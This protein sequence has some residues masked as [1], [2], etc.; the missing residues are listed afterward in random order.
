MKM[1]NNN[2]DID[3][4]RELGSQPIKR[5]DGIEQDVSTLN[6]KQRVSHILSSP[7]FKEELEQAVTDVILRPNNSGDQNFAKEVASY[8]SLNHRPGFKVFEGYSEGGGIQALKA[9]V[10][11]VSPINDLTGSEALSAYSKHERLTR[12]KLAT[13][14]RIVDLFGWS[15]HTCDGNLS[16]RLS[17][18]QEHFLVSPYGLLYHEVSAGKLVKVNM[19]GEALD[20]GSTTLSSIN[21]AS[22]SLHSAIYAA[23]PD[24]HCVVHVKTPEAIAVS[25]MECGILPL[26]EESLLIGEVSVYPYNRPLFE[27]KDRKEMQK[28]LGA[29]NKVMLVRNRGVVACGHTIEE[30]HLHLNRVILAC[31]TQVKAMSCVT[32][33]SDK[34]LTMLDRTQ[35]KSSVD[36]VSSTSDEDGIEWRRGEIEFEALVRMLDNMGYRSGY[37]YR[38]P[39]VVKS[40]AKQLDEVAEPPTSFNIQQH[41]RNGRD[42]ARW[43]NSPNLYMKKKEKDC[44][45]VNGSTCSSVNGDHSPKATRT[46]WLRSGSPSSSSST[47][48]TS[49]N[50]VKTKPN[51][52][53]PTGTDPREVAAT[54]KSIRGQAHKQSNPPGP[55]SQLL[56]SHAPKRT[57][58]EVSS[59]SKAII[60]RGVSVDIIT[61]QG[62]LNPFAKVSNEELENYK[63]NLL[64][65]SNNHQHQPEEAVEKKEEEID[66][67][68]AADNAVGETQHQEIVVVKV[69]KRD[70][71]EKE[72]KTEISIKRNGI[73]DEQQVVETATT[74]TTTTTIK[75]ERSTSFDAAISSS[76]MQRLSTAEAGGGGTSAS[77]TDRGG[78]EDENV[79][80]P[81]VKSPGVD[82]S[83]AADVKSPASAAKKKKKRPLSFLKKKKQK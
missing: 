66:D 32:K 75:A 22:F 3:I 47:T 36:Q 10:G 50:A 58:L 81:T 23:R 37:S 24:I 12:C 13:L 65:S 28:C 78:S 79:P 2:H 80:P 67:E 33:T 43:V 57:G 15:L 27:A 72:E 35:F 6:Q 45:E 64:Q 70:D 1:S 30:A 48:V 53:V 5:P 11:R 55:Q 38:N 56:H 16:T 4:V 25:C 68:T 83:T 71:Q 40:K 62:P 54:R 29:T 26:C 42:A 44:D 61:P 17:K 73:A 14:H 63:K 82:A 7:F 51:Q 34:Q 19:R 41:A 9:G 77:S 20:G 21:R 46:K 52:F 31:N 39:D 49:A 18:E 60:E 69:V 59:G 8:F 74:T 76:Q